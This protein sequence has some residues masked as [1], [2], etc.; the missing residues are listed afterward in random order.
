MRSIIENLIT[1]HK[2]THSKMTW[3]R[4]VIL[5]GQDGLVN[6]LGIVL[7]VS[8]GA[9]L[10]PASVFGYYRLPRIFGDCFVCHGSL[11][12]ESLRGVMA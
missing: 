11:R 6:V 3:M 9:L 4:D 5:G 2:E 7:E 10:F 12:G 8:G 1:S